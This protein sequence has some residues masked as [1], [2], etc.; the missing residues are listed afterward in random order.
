MENINDAAV[1]AT[2][3]ITKAKPYTLKP[4]AGEHIVPMVS[5]VRKIGLKELKN[6]ISEETI[7]QV[8]S[9]FT[10]TAEGTAEGTEKDENSR[11]DTFAAI[12][13]SILPTAFDIAEVLF[14]NIEKAEADIFK[15]LA[16]VS[17]LSVEQIKKLPI[18]DVFEMIIDV[19]KKEEFKDFFSVV[20]KLFK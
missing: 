16:S 4:L 1:Q 3:E 9:L 18:A 17:D 19:V 11:D 20:S 15:F 8:V 7:K 14:A 13:I 10:G 12:G 2:E 6:C 5:I